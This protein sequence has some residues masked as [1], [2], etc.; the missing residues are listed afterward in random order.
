VALANKLVPKTLPHDIRADVCQELIVSI[1]A[2]DI[3]RDQAHDHVQKHIGR[4]FKSV[5]FKFVPTGLKMSLDAPV[6][7]DDEDDRSLHDIVSDG[8]YEHWSDQM[9]ETNASA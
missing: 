8:L 5:E 9:E 3:T 6:R 2:G 7:M 4:V 1:L